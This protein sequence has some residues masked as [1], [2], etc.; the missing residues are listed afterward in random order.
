MKMR[1]CFIFNCLGFVAIGSILLWY[2][3][4]FAKDIA[5]SVANCDG[6]YCIP[7]NTT[8][9]LCPLSGTEDSPATSYPEETH[10]NIWK[11]VTLLNP[12]VLTCNPFKD[13]DLCDTEP[14][15][16]PDL[17]WVKLG[18]KAVCAIHYEPEPQERRR[19]QQ[20]SEIE[21]DMTNTNNRNDNV[22][23]EVSTV[24]TCENSA[25]YKIKTY[26][27]QKD[28]ELAGGF[29]THI[30]H[31]GV[32]SSLQDLAVYA[33]V[34]FMGVTSPGNFCRQQ[35]A[36]SLE[37]GLACYR[38]LGM[39]QDCSK[40]WADTSWNTAS[41]CFNSCIVDPTLPIFGG[42]DIS[43]SNSST[44][45]ENATGTSSNKWY[46]FPVTLKERLSSSLDNNGV[47]SVSGPYNG[48]APD[49]ALND[50]LRCSEEV[51][52]PTFD[53]IA[54]R[55][56]RRSGLLSTAVFPC[57]RSPRILQDPCPVTQPI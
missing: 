37:N 24:G 51:S 9:F 48:P 5:D 21:V 38:G 4:F 27:S 19:R 2:F 53:K 14:P 23:T 52:V 55:N 13:G 25:F 1:S 42:N 26:P 12:I 44:D 43:S 29:V 50:C 34:D 15:V 54:G 31:C 30:G 17:Q 7:D 3:F 32:C 18:E 35:A 40:I 20:Q 39:T 11:S 47:N 16:D 8:S 28:A 10:L 56:R 57:G 22:T 41:N 46:D 6:C 36:L 33:N 49:C 45:G